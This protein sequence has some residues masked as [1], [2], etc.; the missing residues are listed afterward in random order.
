[1]SFEEK[2]NLATLVIVSVI[3]GGYFISLASQA[4]SGGL[5]ADVPGAAFGPVFIGLSI[6]LAQ[7]CVSTPIRPSSV[8]SV[9]TEANFS[10]TS[11]L[12]QRSATR[13]SPPVTSE[14]SPNSSVLSIL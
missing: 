8:R 4:V 14:V 5:P 13:C 1:M 12:R 2:S 7:R 10:R 6:G 9:G 3:F 11:S